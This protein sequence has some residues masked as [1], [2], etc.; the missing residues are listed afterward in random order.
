MRVLITGAAGGIGR[1]VAQSFADEGH[2]VI[3]VDR[4]ARPETFAGEWVERDL[5]GAPLEPALFRGVDAVLHLAAVPGRGVVSDRELFINNSS[6]TYS[7]LDAACTAGVERIVI[8]SSISIYGT[9]WADR[10]ITPAELPLRETSEIRP[11]EAYALAKE[12][13]ESI[14][15]MMCRRFDVSIALLRLPRVS[16]VEHI[17]ERSVLVDRDAAEAS[18]EL[19]A[20]LTLDDAAEAFRRAAQAEFNGCLAMTVVSPQALNTID[21][22][23]AATQYYPNT[24]STL[25]HGEPGLS[26]DVAKRVLGFTPRAVLPPAR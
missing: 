20:Y 15:R 4:V 18:R 6:S 11:A 5:A 17:I 24:P 10:E 23:T 9:V 22:A 26:I 13:D 3:G 19:W 2:G 12:V 16:S 7:V 21:V 25:S 14:A 1:V 8:A